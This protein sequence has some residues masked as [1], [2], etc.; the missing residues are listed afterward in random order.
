MNNV[1]ILDIPFSAKTTDET[2]LYLHEQIQKQEH[3][4]LFH[5]VTANPEIAMLT[6]K[7]RK[8]K[9]ILSQASLIT[10]DGIGIVI[11]SKILGTPLPERVAGYDTLHRFLTYRETNRVKT[12]IFAVGAK[13]EVIQ[14]AVEKLKETYPLVE[15]VGYHNGYFSADS[16][17]EKTIVHQINEQKPDLL[18]VGLGAPRQE[19]FIYTYKKDL[20]AKV[21]IG[22]GG[23]FDVLSGKT[24]RAPALFQRL[25]LE[26]FWR[27]VSQPS[28]W[29]RQLMIPQFVLEVLKEKFSK[30]EK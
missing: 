9:R 25:Y 10:P 5:V 27:L 22:V 24:K 26:W 18:L 6:R 7:S 11:G 28:R 20:Q 19:E 21:A 17:E 16:E 23:S 2:V 3:E 12:K 15:I 29:K 30:K 1:P 14:L 13:E 4:E 8:F